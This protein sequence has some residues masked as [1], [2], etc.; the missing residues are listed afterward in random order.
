MDMKEFKEQCLDNI[1]REQQLAEAQKAAGK[2]A[3]HNYHD[4]RMQVW[5]SVHDTLVRYFSDSG[6]GE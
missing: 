4:G 5:L 1:K 2:H 3:M 6:K